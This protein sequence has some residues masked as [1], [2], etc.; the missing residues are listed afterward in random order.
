MSDV[1]VVCFRADIVLAES[2]KTGSVVTDANGFAHVTLNTPFMAPYIIVSSTGVSAHPTVC[3]ASNFADDGFDLN[4]YRATS[5]QPDPGILVF[6]FA[7]LV[8]NP[9]PRGQNGTN[10]TSGT[11]GTSGT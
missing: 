3:N 5:G 8:Y 11:D 10:G 9:Y 2:T 7:T 1:D 4:T 6:W